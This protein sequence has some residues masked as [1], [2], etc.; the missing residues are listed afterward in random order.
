MEAWGAVQLAQAAVSCWASPALVR[1][2]AAYSPWTVPKEQFRGLPPAG[3][4]ARWALPSVLSTVP[5]G[6]AELDKTVPVVRQL[7]AVEPEPVQVPLA[8]QA[9]AAQTAGELQQMSH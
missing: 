6:A 9:E 4:L 5:M 7:S 2:D 1:R 3:G 8:W